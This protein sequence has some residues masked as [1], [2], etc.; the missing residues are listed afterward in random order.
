MFKNMLKAY[1]AISTTFGK[2][3][4]PIF[5]FMGI[6]FLR[7][8]VSAGMHLD[9]LFFPS[10]N[11]QKIVNPIIV[12]GNPRSGTTFLQRFL[13][14]RNIGVGLKLWKMIFP[15]LTLQFIFK[16][17]LSYL[18]KISPAR[19][20]Q[21]AAHETS[22]TAIET[23]D[24]SL[25]FHFFDGFFVYGFFLAWYEEDLVAD[26]DPVIHNTSERDFNWLE[27]IWKRNLIGEKH[28]REIA[29]LFS[30]GVRIPAFLEYFPDAKILYMIRDPL[31][32]VPSGLSLIT[33]VLD[34]RFGFWKLP[35][36]KKKMYIE[37]L[38]AAFLELSMRFHDDYI[39]NKIDK[40]NFIV[41]RYDRMM[42]DFENLMKE[43]IPFL[44]ITPSEE[45]INEIK[46]TSEKQSKFKSTHKYSL[47]KF[48]LNE[49]RI[50]KDYEMIY[51]TFFL[52]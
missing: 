48:G 14:N 41:I 23:D 51:R 18:E 31:E 43:I 20:H 28:S 5:T 8:V 30:L 19:F 9:Y 40:N 24:P 34:G 39:G 10:L 26:F 12:V 3:I 2:P 29:K 37:R 46:K 50:R 1:I 16:P 13:V 32:T 35:E 22:L 27:Q 7:I 47:E 17:I 49:E 11:K 4:S 44:E 45:L 33:G 6:I 38:Y 42:N 21:H 15:S 36:A 25:M 52:N